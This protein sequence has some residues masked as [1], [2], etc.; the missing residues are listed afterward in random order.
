M[1][2]I[3]TGAAGALGRAVVARL[4]AEG[5]RVACIDM[6]AGDEAGSR[7]WF[8]SEDLADEESANASVRAAMDWLGGIDCLVH[9]A[10]GFD[11]MTVENST[12]GDWKRLFAVNV[13]TAVNAIQALLPHLGSGSAITLIGAASAQ[14]AG[15]GM[16][17]YAVSKS[18]ISRLVEALSRELAGRLI[19]VNAVLPSIIDTPRNRLDMPDADFGSWTKPE[20]IADVIA[21]LSSPASRA[22]NGASIPVTNGG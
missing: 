2:T 1:R 4:E 11:W 19:R 15:E 21:F 12:L 16:G 5:H 18:G 22:I 10:G 8:I 7:A 13:E 6:V 9:V 3:V 20:A 14:P 17:P